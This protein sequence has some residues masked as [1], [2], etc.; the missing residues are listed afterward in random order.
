MTSCQPEG[1]R[2]SEMERE[3]ER[4]IEM[5]TKSEREKALKVFDAFQRCIIPGGI[6]NVDY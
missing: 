2:E 3:R 4:E 1:L 6:H 5:E